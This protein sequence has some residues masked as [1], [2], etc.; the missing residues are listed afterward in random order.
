MK[1]K[2]SKKKVLDNIIF[3]PARNG[4]TRI[5]NKNL[6]KINGVSLLRK[7]ILTCKKSGIGKI[8]ISSNCKKILKEASKLKGVETF[9]RQEKYATAKA[10]TISTILEYLR[11]LFKKELPIPNFITLVPVTNPFLNH[12]T[13]RLG[14]TKIKKNKHLSS[15]IGITESSE[16][17]FS[18]VTVG[19][20][21]TFNIFKVNGKKGSDF[22]R[23]QDRPKTY[24]QSASFRISKTNYFLKFLSKKSPTFSK[25]NFNQNSCGY[26]KI[27]KIENFD[28]NTHDDLRLAKFMLK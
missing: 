13:L 22:E 20:K 25:E 19:K 27:K 26:I 15:V 7:K 11:S 28:I 18:T 1:K 23:S 8:V 4:S 21:L 16:H 10:S 17:P 3:I 9:K 12:K 5:K 2:S 24:V 14:Y 6:R